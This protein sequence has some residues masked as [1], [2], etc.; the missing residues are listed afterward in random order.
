[1]KWLVQRRWLA[2]SAHDE[3]KGGWC[4]RPLNITKDVHTALLVREPNLQTLKDGL[5]HKLIQ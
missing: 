5:T 1:M 4:V 3:F 2:Y